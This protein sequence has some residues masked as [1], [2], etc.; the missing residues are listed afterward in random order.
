[1]KHLGIYK[2]T[3]PIGKS[4]IGQSMDIERR[5]RTHKNNNNKPQSDIYK[6]IDEYGWNNFTIEILWGTDNPERYKHINTLLDTLEKAWIKKYDT[7]ENGYNM[8][9]GGMGGFKLTEEAKKKIGLAH[10]GKT[11][12][13]EQRNKMVEG[14]KEKLSIN[15]NQYSKDGTFIQSW[16]SLTEAGKS[17]GI[18]ISNISKVCKGVN[19]TAGGYIWKYTENNNK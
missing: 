14:S 12:S 18:P 5:I 11:I 16:V 4:Y 13:Q 15:V 9:S 6:A 10:R 7:V 2:I 17:Y 3:S 8:Q 1:M 19:K